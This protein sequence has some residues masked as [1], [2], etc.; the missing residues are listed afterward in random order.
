M[1][2]VAYVRWR[3]AVMEDADSD[4]IAIAKPC[5]LEEVGWLLDENKD[6]ILIGLER[7]PDG[8]RA[9]RARLHIPRANII[10]LRVMD[11]NRAFPKRSV[12]WQA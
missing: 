12:V 3:D 7:Q 8:I 5:E 9:G 2:R 1:T 10:E 11:F 6:A 4:S